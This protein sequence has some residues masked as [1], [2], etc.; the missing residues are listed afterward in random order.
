M[1]IPI[2]DDLPGP[3]SGSTPFA[4]YDNDAE[5]QAA[6][7]KMARWMARRLGYPIMN[8][9]LQSGSFYTAFEEA[10]NTYGSEIYNQKIQDNYLLMEGGSTGSSINNT[11][12]TPN[13]GGIIR[14]AKGYGSEAGS[15]GNVTYYT[16]S[17]DLTPGQQNYDLNAWAAVSASLAEGDNI[18][19]KRIFNDRPPAI[20]RY[21]DPYAGTGN[22]LQGLMDSFGFGNMSPAISFTLMPI[23]FDLQKLQS[24]EFN[25]EI[26]RSA[27][28]FELVNN[29]LRIFPIP[30]D[31]D[32]EKLFF[33]YIKI[34]ERD[35]AWKN[36]SASGSGSN[37]SITNPSQVPYENIVY[38]QI[39]NPGKQ[40]INNYA[41]AIAKEMLGRVRRKYATTPVPG[42]EVTLDGDL[43]LTEAQGEKEKLLEQLRGML[44]ITGRK[45]QLENAQLESDYINKTLANVP[46]P[47]YIA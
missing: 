41:L 40:W 34:S 36:T 27:W 10:I 7:P 15:G 22:G 39:N 45:Q 24:I 44:G 4:F 20:V 47:I 32:R 46:L 23:Y 14:I 38:S 18:E 9:E 42:A 25:D 26:R 21:F 33:H 19:I 13:L 12:V 30:G 6:A 5:F 31:D 37:G 1:D 17:I 35:N 43:L 8:V 16:G 2:W 11:V 28:T 3:I 29:H